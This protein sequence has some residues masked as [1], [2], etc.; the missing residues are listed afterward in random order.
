MAPELSASQATPLL[1]AAA[2]AAPP[3]AFGQDP[4]APSG[5]E[6]APRHGQ[7]RTAAAAVHRQLA[8]GGEYPAEEPGEH[9]LFDEDVH[10]PGRGAKHDGAVE[11]TD[12]VAGEDH[13]AGR[14]DV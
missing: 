11:E 14:R 3:R 1:I 12:V 7:R 5:V 10:G 4:D 8:R 2:G 13:G 6:Q 9:L